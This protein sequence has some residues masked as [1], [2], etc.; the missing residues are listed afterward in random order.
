[1]IGEHLINKFY[2]VDTLRELVSNKEHGL[3]NQI[4]VTI[5]G[6]YGEHF[7]NNHFSL[8]MINGKET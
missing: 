7:Y 1:M 3:F 4:H 5:T 6:I 8:V 2:M